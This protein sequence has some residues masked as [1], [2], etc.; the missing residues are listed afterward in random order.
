MPCTLTLELE[1]PCS[2]C[3]LLDLAR[4]QY[5][6]GTTDSQVRC[7]ACCIGHQEDA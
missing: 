7:V 2:V 5:G 4:Q 1:V 3:R 6:L